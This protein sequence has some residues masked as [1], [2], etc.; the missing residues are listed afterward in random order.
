MTNLKATT[1]VYSCFFIVYNTITAK[2]IN[3]ID[4]FISCLLSNL[5]LLRAK[6]KDPFIFLKN[7]INEL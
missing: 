4:K 6:L 5:T 2:E 7:N 1:I 3:K